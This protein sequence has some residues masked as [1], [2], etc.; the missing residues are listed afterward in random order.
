MKTIEQVREFINEKRNNSD[1]TADILYEN[2]YFKSAR[3][4][5]TLMLNLDEILDF[6]DSEET[7]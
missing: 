3:F 4:F 5:R 1:K 7:S 2:N 6:I